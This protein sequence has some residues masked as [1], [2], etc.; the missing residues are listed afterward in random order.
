MNPATLAIAAREQL[1][2]RSTTPCL[3]WEISQG[4]VFR[5][6]RPPY[7]PSPLE[8]VT[9]ESLSAWTSGRSGTKSVKFE[10]REAADQTFASEQLQLVVHGSASQIVRKKGGVIVLNSVKND[11]ALLDVL[12]GLIQGGAT[13]VPPDE[14]PPSSQLQSA[15]LP[16]SQTPSS[17]LLVA[18]NPSTWSS[19]LMSRG[20]S[21]LWIRDEASFAKQKARELDW[22][23]VV[24]APLTAIPKVSAHRWTRVIVLSPRISTTEAEVVARLDADCKWLVCSASAVEDQRAMKSSVHP[25]STS[26]HYH[27]LHQLNRVSPSFSISSAPPTNSLSTS[28]PHSLPPAPYN[29]PAPPT[30]C[31]PTSP[32]NAPA[33]PSIRRTTTS[34]RSLCVSLICRT[35]LC[36]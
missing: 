6:D 9:L 2:E 33:P 32:P 30:Q 34:G 27:H 31:S 26:L 8:T 4:N 13:T 3:N 14:T 23:G 18:S 20:L 16:A 35:R 22:A 24:V 12:I 28:K 7:S 17:T 10:E 5:E 29:A 11:P 1:P 36:R 21:T 19:K 15:N 25:R